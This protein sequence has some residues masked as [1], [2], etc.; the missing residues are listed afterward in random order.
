MMRD[1]KTPLTLWCS[2]L[3][4][5]TMFMLL[6]CT[7]DVGPLEDATEQ[8]RLTSVSSESRIY[9]GRQIFLSVHCDDEEN[10][11][12]E[13]VYEWTI[14]DENGN[15]VASIVH[16]EYVPQGREDDSLDDEDDEFSWPNADEISFEFLTEGTFSVRTDLHE[17]S[18]YRTL[19][20]LAPR[21]GTFTR[22][23]Y[24]DPLRVQL[25]ATPSGE[26]R[27]YRLTATI[28]NKRHLTLY[29]YPSWRFT[30]KDTWIVDSWQYVKDSGD[31]DNGTT[32]MTSD[33]DDIFGKGI[34]IITHKFPADGAYTVQFTL[35]DEK[36]KIA[37]AEM[38]VV[39]KGTD[40]TIRL[41]ELPLKV[42]TEY[43]LVA[44]NNYPETTPSDPLFDWD[45][46]DG[47]GIRIPFS[48][49][50]THLYA[51]EGS[52]TV[53]V[54][55]FESGDQG[56]ALLGEATAKVTVEPVA[57]YLAQLQRTKRF[58]LDFAVKQTNTNGQTHV[59][60]W[61]WNSQGELTWDGTSFSM[62][63]SKDGH[64]ETLTGTVAEDGASVKALKLRHEFAGSSDT[65]WYEIELADFPLW[66]P[67][68]FANDVTRPDVAD[69]V[70]YFN[71]HRTAGFDWTSDARIY[72]QFRD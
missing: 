57:D 14:Q 44:L 60:A 5:S 10:R 11:P 70:T 7:G 16:D 26:G 59:F 64:S 47:Q 49:E 58:E 38:E 9:P 23:V 54:K 21:R 39:V 32:E 35:E 72:V 43:T 37:T 31:I 62:N 48:N 68:R 67:D 24:V 46:G 71:S 25:Q 55:L 33:I 69:Y 8:S 18:E 4:L 27:S 28:E 29:C 56:D 40:L 2:F 65:E 34:N 17:K 15:I 61:D 66:V 22:T 19:K 41:P 20:N 45:F 51:E 13:P 3:L 50:V 52:Y 63:W 53:R 30:S 6:S 42:G 36:L 12:D 1:V